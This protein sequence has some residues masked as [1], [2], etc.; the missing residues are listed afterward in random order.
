MMI[1]AAGGKAEAPI[2]VVA[3]ETRPLVIR[4]RT[5]RL[6]E[7]SAGSVGPGYALD[8]FRRLGFA[9][10]TAPDGIEVTV[11]TYRGDIHEEMDLIEEVLRFFGLDRVPASL[12]RMT[13]GVPVVLIA[14]AWWSACA[15]RRSGNWL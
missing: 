8:L 12:P 15:Y 1:E 14:A 6:H 10:T 2:D 9:A 11:P 3:N 13:V 4:L 7:A 5:T